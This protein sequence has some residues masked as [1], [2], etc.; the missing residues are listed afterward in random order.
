[1]PL[2]IG[3]YINIFFAFKIN[4]ISKN[5][6]LFLLKSSFITNNYLIYFIKLNLHLLAGGVVEWFKALVLKTN[7]SI[8]RRK[9][10]ILKNN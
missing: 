7:F 2:T 8:W 3:V 9:N 4:N 10:I 1:M 6:A 5:N